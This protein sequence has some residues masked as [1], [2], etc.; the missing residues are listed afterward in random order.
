MLGCSLCMGNQARVE[1]K[2]TVISTSTRNFPNRL[3][4]GANV[5]L[6]S[7]ELAAVCSALGKIPNMEEYMTYMN[8]LNTMAGE[9]YRYMNFNEIQQYMQGAENAK[10][11]PLQNIQEVQTS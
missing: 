9:I 1:A 2:S 3:G 7:A 11:I 6:G 10:N 5:Y 4:D 8:S